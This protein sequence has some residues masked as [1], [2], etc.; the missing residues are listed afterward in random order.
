[1]IIEN[2][3]N[4]KADLRP[5]ASQL[6]GEMFGKLKTCPQSKPSVSSF[7]IENFDLKAQIQTLESEL[8][9]E[10]DKNR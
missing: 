5:N 1:V 7:E 9:N 4:S 2:L 10:R 6:L 3:L 8:A